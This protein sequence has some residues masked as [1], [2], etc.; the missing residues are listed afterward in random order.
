MYAIIR[1]GGKQIKVSPGD[2]I[3]VEKLTANEGDEITL[4]EV[5]L[6]SKDDSIQIG[7]PL[8]PETAVKATVLAH[9]RGKK[10]IV[11]KLKRRKQYRR[12]HGHRQDYTRLRIEE[13]IES[14]E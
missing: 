11:F 13:I 9:G 3:E 7:T 12:K 2:I 10:V 1:T 6:T 8:V 14:G 5:L 4:A